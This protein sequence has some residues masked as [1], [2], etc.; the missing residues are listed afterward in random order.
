M[1]RLP[2]GLISLRH[3]LLKQPFFTSTLLPLIPRPIRWVL[4]KVYFLPL[5]MVERVTGERDELVPRR[6]ANFTGS[7][8]GFRRT[9]TRLVQQLVDLAGLTPRD[10][11]L[12][13]GCG[14][15]RLAVALIDYLEAPGSYKGLD[16]VPSGIKWCQDTITP[17]HSQFTFTLADVHNREYNPKGRFR[18][19]EYT[20]PYSD[21]H[22]DLVVL[23]SVFTHM[24]PAGTDRY[25]H[26]VRR[27]LKKEGRCFA[28]FFLINDE[29]RELMDSGRSSLMFKHELGD[30]WLVNSR[31]PELSVG[32]K[33]TYIRDLCSKVFANMQVFYG[34]WC[35]RPPL[36]SDAA[37]L[38]DQDVVILTK[39][40]TDP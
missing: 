24:L 34:G 38:G 32:Y 19:S 26:E 22:F 16:I 2:S 29:S 14:V 12:D 36:W 21:E 37:G 20:F 5:D 15:G 4:R 27:V 6:G 31:V 3:W 8:D 13:I 17:K 33:E 30:Y 9:G 28:T 40:T 10:H 1:N 25:L 39:T 35:G 7:A 18:A 11:V 23:M